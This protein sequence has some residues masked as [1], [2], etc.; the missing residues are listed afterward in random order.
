MMK[1]RW[2]G[3]LGVLA[4]AVLWGTLLGLQGVSAK[5]TSAPVDRATGIT[6]ERAR[7][8]EAEAGIRV[9]RSDASGIVF[10]LNTPAYALELDE[11]ADCEVLSVEGYGY[12]SRS[13]W[14]RLPVRGA[15]IGVP[16]GADVSLSVASV[17]SRIVPGAHRLCP[18]PTLQAETSP[19]DSVPQYGGES[20]VFDSRAYA[21]PGLQPEAIARITEVGWLRDRRVAQLELTP[22]RY[23]AAT[24]E[25]H[26]MQHMRVHLRFEGG[27]AV[28][29]AAPGAGTAETHSD[30]FGDPGAALLLNADA[31][32][33]WR[34]RRP[35][36]PIQPGLQATQA[37]SPSYKLLV[38]RD[39][40][41]EVT[42]VELAAVGVPVD[43]ID[44]R[45]FQVTNHGV[46]AAIEV[47]GEDDGS[48][49]SGDTLVFYGEKTD[50]RYTDTNVYWLS[51][52]RSS[53]RRMPQRSVTPHSA[54]SPL[55]S[56][57]ANYH[58]E[59]N[60]FYQSLI[61]SGDDHWFADYINTSAPASK[62]F[63]FTLENVATL[64]Y[65]ATMRGELFGYS[66]FG[67]SPDHHTRVYLN[68]H[69]VD[70]ATW[71]GF[72]I[73]R[74]EHAIPASYLVEGVNDITIELPFDFTG[75]VIS[76]I[77]IFNWFDLDYRDRFVAEE[78]KL[79]F[80]KNLSGPHLFEVTEFTVGTLEA[81]DVTSPTHPVRLDDVSVIGHAGDFSLTFEETVTGT[82]R[83]L[84]Q[85]TDRRLSPPSIE[86]DVPSVWRDSSNG[87]DYVIITHGDFYTEV[88]ALADHRAA[89]GL[90]VAVVD[91]QDVYDE[92]NGG[93]FH[94][95]AIRDF[96]TYTYEQWTV[97]SPSYVLLVGDGTFDFKDIYGR[98]E[99]T[100]I[101]PYLASVDPWMG[102][103]A[104]DNRYVAVHGEDIFP[105]MHL[106]RMPVSKPPEAAAMVDKVITYETTSPSGDWTQRV[107]FVADNPDDAG[108][109]YALSDSVIDD[110]LPGPYI[111]DRIYYRQTHST[112]SVVKSAIFSGFDEGR[113]MVNYIGHATIDFWG[114]EHF[115]D[116]DD[117]STLNNGGRQPFV[118]P[119]TCLEGYYIQPNSPSL[120]L[121]SFA[122][123]LVRV[124][125]KG[126]IASW[127][128]TGFGVAEGHDFLNR[129]LYDAIFR[130]GVTQVGPATTQA[131][132]YLAAQTGG[133]RELIDTYLLFGDPALQLPILGADVGITKDGGPAGPLWPGDAVTYTLAYTNAG[134]GTAANVVITDVLPSGLLNPVVV[135][136]GATITPRAGSR[137]VWD[138]A[139]LGP[140]AGGSI[141][142]TAIVSPTFHG[143]LTNTA[144]IATTGVETAT[145]NNAAGP[146]MI[147]VD[148]PD[149]G[150]EKAGPD[151]AGAG[152]WV[153]Y[154]LTYANTGSRLAQGVAI[155]DPL[156]SALTDAGV[157]SSGAVITP[158][159]GSRYAWDVADL[160]PGG[161]GT[162][163]VTAR[164]SPTFQGVISNTAVIATSG[165]DVNPGNNRSAPVRTGVDTPDLHIRKHGPADSYSYATVAYTLVYTNHGPAP[166]RQV[167]ITDV[168]P[169]VLR[170]PTV[171]SSGA[172]ITQRAGSR[173]VWDVAD[174]APSVGG[175]ITI[176]ARI[177]ATFTDTLTNTATIATDAIEWAYEN[178]VDRLV[179]TVDRQVLYL[180]V[181]MRV[182]KQ[183]R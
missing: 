60:N 117:I 116:R 73:Y 62:T 111:P 45:T 99:R 175:T 29:P 151:D 183:G 109:F 155:T 118:V 130:N 95:E 180:P 102:E 27:I 133:Y 19:D 48:F 141:T 31:A 136:S 110:H 138:V 61:P 87:A 80:S 67:P 53:G 24:G 54:I 6:T 1:R 160:V 128:P 172:V 15:L 88:Q 3:M 122:E 143:T 58:W 44:P 93:V 176:T 37:I 149:L 33:H 98:G 20:L 36:A 147:Q 57:D 139:D 39:G 167:V 76:D 30:P 65:S 64:P 34:V 82:R 107:L 169:S 22:F 120:N 168:L 32:Q 91:V 182:S 108:D 14:P 137:F 112:G 68:G 10:E 140:G 28:A 84:V 170:N 11:D 92:F 79:R 135:S 97:P 42:Y 55:P 72:R 164:I 41:Y 146:V 43:Q 35:V 129:S 94:P 150:I 142:L 12:T 38:D 75:D 85:A 90:R 156:A 121:S 123:T 78:D 154:T 178:N 104:A 40:L 148:A 157:V 52:G 56:Y 77:V 181:V 163:T 125:G 152:D 83:Y 69:L 89:Q 23:D 71:D 86:A 173:F 126:A 70:D 134:P 2:A 17:E 115:F 7:E 46:E 74:F 166:A 59:E 13:G 21:N 105:D 66:H 96:L 114:F 171:L 51:W 165:V 16:P 131:K 162:I 177:D 158:R 103:T 174:L 9:I 50:T 113:L 63:T 8:D 18:V 5:P 124:S 25:L 4:L 119:M 47:R 26:H 101:P 132:L 100:Y 127:S 106:G 153:T 161:E 81:Y 145:A 179:T 49:D 159:A 144:Q